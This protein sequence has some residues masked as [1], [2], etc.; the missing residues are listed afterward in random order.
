MSSASASRKPGRAER[1]IIAITLDP[2][3]GCV[4]SV[5]CCPL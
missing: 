4:R 2:H 3:S 5:T 1:C